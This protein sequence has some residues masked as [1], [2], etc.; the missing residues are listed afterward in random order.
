MW[1]SWPRYC[2]TLHNTASLSQLCIEISEETRISEMCFWPSRQDAATRDDVITKPTL[3]LWMDQNV[4][5][6]HYFLTFQATFSYA[7]ISAPINGPFQPLTQLS[8][9]PN[10][11]NLR[12]GTLNVSQ[13]SGDCTPANKKL[14]QMCSLLFLIPTWPWVYPE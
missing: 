9:F 3:R 6:R 10:D 8:A 7:P 5:T 14:L 12:H 11:L 13:I 4:M 2:I 1:G